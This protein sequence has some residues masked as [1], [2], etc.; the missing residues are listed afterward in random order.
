M[1]RAI[2][3]GFRPDGDSPNHHCRF[4]TRRCCPV[5]KQKK[6]GCAAAIDA[7]RAA[8]RS[9][10]RCSRRSPSCCSR[11][12]QRRAG[13]AAVAA[14]HW[15]SRRRSA[16]PLPLA[17]PRAAA[18]AVAAPQARPGRPRPVPTCGGKRGEA[19]LG[20]VVKREEARGRA[21]HLTEFDS[22]GTVP[23]LTAPS[24]AALAAPAAAARTLRATAA[25]DPVGKQGRKAGDALGQDRRR[26]GHAR[27][28]SHAARHRASAAQAPLLRGC[29]P[30]QPALAGRRRRGG[31]PEMGMGGRSG[32]KAGGEEL[33]GGDWERSS[34][35]AVGRG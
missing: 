19:R 9:T 14:P 24:A 27:R 30:P 12:S 13:A 35:G 5:R 11:R 34:E 21:P 3:A 17:A 10:R 23:D 6:T 18:A 2:T 33:G 25:A 15:C 1:D 4:E 28:Q 32:E 26:R 8:R 22:H 20:A 29:A 7:R 16:A 31:R